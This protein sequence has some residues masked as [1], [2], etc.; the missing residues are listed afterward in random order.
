[1]RFPCCTRDRQ[2]LG[3]A[4][5][6]LARQAHPTPFYERGLGERA[7][8]GGSSFC[9]KRSTSRSLRGP[10]KAAGGFRHHHAHLDGRGE[11]TPSWSAFGRPVLWESPRPSLRLALGPPWRWR[12]LQDPRDFRRRVTKVQSEE[13]RALWVPPL[14]QAQS[15]HGIRS[16]GQGPLVA[17]LGGP[18]AEAHGR[19]RPGGR[20]RAMRAKKGEIRKCHKSPARE[21][22]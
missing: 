14:R 6:A 12:E 10:G 13:T 18:C 5:L 15:G 20:A 9:S 4:E 3:L 16:R 8:W 19:G 2:H 21:K 7:Q 22:G 11:T 1:M 17:T